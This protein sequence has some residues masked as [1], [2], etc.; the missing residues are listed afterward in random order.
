MNGDSS[1]SNRAQKPKLLDM[2]LL[3]R[4]SGDKWIMAN[5][6]YGAGLRLLECLRLRVGDIDFNY[7]Q[8]I[9]RDGK[10]EKTGLPC[11]LVASWIP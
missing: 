3:S 9:V 1:T 6:L 7:R 2:D 8:I 5:M 4:L 11:C 10:G